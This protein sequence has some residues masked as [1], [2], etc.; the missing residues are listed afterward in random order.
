MQNIPIDLRD[1]ARDRSRIA[2]LAAHL[3]ADVHGGEDL[4]QESLY[5]LLRV[6][7][8]RGPGNRLAW[9]R[10]AVRRLAANEH[11]GRT[12][13]QER[14]HE[15]ARPEATL[16]SSQVAERAELCQRVHRAIDS[17]PREQANVLRDHYF[18][19]LT[20]SEIADRDGASVNTIKS[21]IRRARTAL[22]EVLEREG[23]GEDTHWSQALALGGLWRTGNFPQPIA[24][25]GAAFT[26]KKAVT[27]IIVLA[28]LVV[29]AYVL[30]R[31]VTH[32]AGSLETVARSGGGVEEID[33]DGE[34]EMA[35]AT[36]GQRR[37]VAP[38]PKIPSPAAIGSL[39]LHASWGDDGSDAA[40]VLLAIIPRGSS[41][42]ELS[43]RLVRTGSDGEVVVRGLI[44][45]SVLIEGDRGGRVEC[46]LVPGE[47]VD[48]EL[49]IPCGVEVLGRVV[50]DRG[51][52]IPAA[53]VWLS[54]GA[55]SYA[56][57]RLVTAS[58]DAGRFR[59]RSVEPMRFV[60]A[61][62]PGL[63]S[64]AVQPLDANAGE[65]LEVEL[66]LN[67]MGATL[68]G[69]V[70]DAE[71]RP[72]AGAR[73]LIGH[74]DDSGLAWMPSFHAEYRP[75]QMT[76]TDERGAFRAHGLA[77]DVEIP[78]WVRANGWSVWTQL[79][80]IAAHGDS[81]VTVQLE[82]GATIRG[83]VTDSAGDPVSGAFVTY[84]N[85][86]WP[87]GRNAFFA[88]PGPH[89]AYS[90]VLSGDE[91]RF[92]IGNVA[93]GS[94]L[95]LAGAGGVEAREELSA[96]EGDSI[97]WN[98]ALVD[99][100]IAGRVVD[101]RGAPIAG[102]EVQ[103]VPAR[104]SGSRKH[105]TTDS[106]GSF[107]CAGLA[108]TP[109]R[110]TFYIPGDELHAGPISRLWGI[111]PGGPEVLVQA[112]DQ[113]IPSSSITGTVVAYEGQG[114][115]AAQVRCSAQGLAWAPEADADAGTGR[116]VIGPLP[117][118]SYKLQTITGDPSRWSAWSDPIV[119]R[120]N[121]T[122]DVGPLELSPPGSVTALVTDADGVTLTGVPVSLEVSTGWS[123][124][125]VQSSTT[126]E[127]IARLDDVSPG[128]YRVRAGGGAWPSVYASVEVQAGKETSVA[129][130]IP[131]SVE[132]RVLIGPPTE[133]TPMRESIEW[134]RDGEF[135]ELWDNEWESS[136]EAA[137]T[138]RL[139]PGDWEVRV[140]SE[141]GATAVS[142]FVVAHDNPPG[143]EHRVHL[144]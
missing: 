124:V 127:G 32:Q 53:D 137:L 41:D 54:T 118:G 63:R 15:A 134:R 31:G 47:T 55:R 13:R 35:V 64:A 18:G 133:S 76:A 56:R 3:V 99:L 129:I 58:D 121:E 24:S 34:V 70:V 62:A 131:A 136:A 11:R 12:S 46:A 90:T 77:H 78:V 115:A 42:P 93:T 126:S 28:A 44:P 87:T 8:L 119:L 89:W 91:G 122:L 116:F 143:T 106:E 120:S 26:M 23:I 81:V 4:A 108:P 139:V 123:A 140:T 6:G 125:F 112:A 27:T 49:V 20:A 110:L 66:V 144:P 19:E 33:S 51:A 14:E 39:R 84:R 9:L 142:Q 48:A 92:E 98:P 71:G 105:T 128:T 95:M 73:V 113:S 97:V 85:A 38:V 16:S 10:M 117:P 52:P 37:K 5:R 102:V 22:R 61:N 65:T 69:S 107:R 141:T 40:G 25:I 36:D 83:R 80:P 96:A 7:G 132:C 79:V 68:S 59:L 111:E 17:L 109:H 86:A 103:C 104:G 29:G 21:R 57:A 100:V 75:Q 138:L 50:D 60:S 135:H 74:S 94:V 101:A 2:A 45:E 1:L 82:R 130:V 88:F 43:Q 30:Q 114:L 67:G 72:V